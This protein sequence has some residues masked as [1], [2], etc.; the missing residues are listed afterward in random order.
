MKYLGVFLI[1]TKMFL[2][3]KNQFLPQR[4]VLRYKIEALLFPILI[5]I[6]TFLKSKKYS[7]ESLE[8]WRDQG[9]FSLLLDSMFLCR[10]T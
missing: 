3:D 6:S 5:N 1:L 2:N 7:K 9:M 8:S 4:L 10:L